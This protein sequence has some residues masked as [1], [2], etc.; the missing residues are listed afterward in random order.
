MHTDN[1][2]SLRAGYAVI[3]T[4]RI[5]GGVHNKTLDSEKDQEGRRLTEK[6]HIVRTVD[7]IEEHARATKVRADAQSVVRQFCA[8]TD[9]SLWC[10][11]DNLPEL[12][13]RV[14]QAKA[15]CEAFNRTASFSEIEYNV[16]IAR[17]PPDDA[18]TTREFIA[19]ARS[20]LEDIQSALVA[21]AP[22]DIR[23]ACVRAVQLQQVLD[24]AS[25]TRLGA[26]VGA[27]R[28]AANVLAANVRKGIDAFEVQL[29]AEALAPV[30]AALFGFIRAAPAPVTEATPARPVVDLDAAARVA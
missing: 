6:K 24:A 8:R 18:E 19:S 20:L 16:V 17:I 1:I 13:E 27:A 7:D 5:R 28:E 30:E 14:K 4:T 2:V 23:A 22:N 21:R 12:R 3:L 26:A 11:D 9:L 25:A 15:M 10:A 29:E